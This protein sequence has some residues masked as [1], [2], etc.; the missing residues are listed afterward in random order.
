[1]YV[2]YVCGKNKQQIKK[3]LLSLK[4][5]FF[6]NPTIKIFDNPMGFR[7]K[8]IWTIGVLLYIIFIQYKV[9]RFFLTF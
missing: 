7:F 8:F 2:F 1:M 5:P 4:S 3:K 6:K 9:V